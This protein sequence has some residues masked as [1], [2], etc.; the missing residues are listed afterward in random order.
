M[1]LRASQ[2]KHTG[3]P[4]LEGGFAMVVQAKMNPYTIT[5]ISNIIQKK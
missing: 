5:L 4:L 1:L 2:G 3:L